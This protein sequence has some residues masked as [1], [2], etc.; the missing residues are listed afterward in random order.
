[1]RCNT[2]GNGF[3]EYRDRGSGSFPFLLPLLDALVERLQDAGVDGCDDVHR[4]V[5]ILLTDS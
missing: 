1:M 4:G 2:S 3:Q 5:E